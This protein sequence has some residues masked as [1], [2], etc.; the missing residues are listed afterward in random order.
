[1]TSGCSGKAS[2]GA[3]VASGVPW[4]DAVAVGSVWLHPGS[5]LCCRSTAQRLHILEDPVRPSSMLFKTR[6]GRCERRFYPVLGRA[7]LNR[8][9]DDA[10]ILGGCCGRYTRT[11]IPTPGRRRRIHV[12][13]DNS[14]QTRNAFTLKCGCVGIRLA[15]VAVLCREAGA[16]NLKHSVTRSF[17]SGSCV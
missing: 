2:I 7:I 5:N 3:G 1:M 8:R 17:A 14:S 6:Y 11:A 9:L 13:V 10:T 4:L 15:V 16:S 12:V